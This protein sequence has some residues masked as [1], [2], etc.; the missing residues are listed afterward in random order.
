MINLPC[1]Q[2]KNLRL[3]KGIVPELSVNIIIEPRFFK[4]QFSFYLKHRDEFEIDF[5]FAIYPEFERDMLIKKFRNELDEIIKFQKNSK[6]CGLGDG[7]G[8]QD[9]IYHIE[10][11]N[12][13]K[14]CS[15]AKLSVTGNNEI[16]F[17]CGYMHNTQVNY[18]DLIKGKYNKIVCNFNC[19]CP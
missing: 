10:N 5:A 6:M 16:F 3:I 1:L 19:T 8:V 14:V 15:E 11:P 18:D 4:N 17:M 7:G 2:V 13:I 9:K 12:K